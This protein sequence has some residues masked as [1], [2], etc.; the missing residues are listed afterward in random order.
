[1]HIY[2]PFHAGDSFW[3]I[4]VQSSLPNIFIS[5]FFHW[6]MSI[7]FLSL[8]LSFKKSYFVIVSFSSVKNVIDEN[9]ETLFVN[10]INTRASASHDE[11]DTCVTDWN[12]RVRFS[13]REAAS[14]RSGATGLFVSESE[15]D[16]QTCV[17]GR[18]ELWPLS[19]GWS[20]SGCCFYRRRVSAETTC[21]EAPP[22]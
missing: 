11:T 8:F 21:S 3:L 13:R 4:S 9:H 14:H 16:G 5:F 7:E 6:Q 2:T 10:G 1:M 20:R 17:S 12:L 15:R 22:S 18:S 19:A